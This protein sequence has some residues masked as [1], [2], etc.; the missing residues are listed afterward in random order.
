M[1]HHDNRTSQMGAWVVIKA[2]WYYQVAE[3]AVILLEWRPFAWKS[4][5]NGHEIHETVIKVTP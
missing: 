4:S 2:G 3:K 1:A 5:H